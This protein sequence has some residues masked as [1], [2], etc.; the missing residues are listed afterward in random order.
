MSISNKNMYDIGNNLVDLIFLLYPFFFLMKKLPNSKATEM[1][2]YSTSESR[3][4][5]KSEEVIIMANLNV[6]SSLMKKV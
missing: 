5:P 6:N 1:G 3:N 4:Q 2:A